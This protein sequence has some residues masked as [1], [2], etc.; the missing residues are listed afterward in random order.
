MFSATNEGL[1]VTELPSLNFKMHEI[2]LP[3]G[4]IKSR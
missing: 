3:S 2:G 4:E 1:S